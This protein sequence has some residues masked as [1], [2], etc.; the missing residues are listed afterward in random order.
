MGEQAL[1][2]YNAY[3][4]SV[5]TA[6]HPYWTTSALILIADIEEPDKLET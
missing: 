4:S 6:P 3:Y 1:L 5:V 2:I